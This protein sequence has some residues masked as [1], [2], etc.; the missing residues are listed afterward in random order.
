MKLEQLNIDLAR[1]LGVQ[2]PEKAS[3]VTLTIKPG[4]LPMVGVTY[5]LLTADG[6][7]TAVHQLQLRPVDW[8][9]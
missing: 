3:E 5:H 1:A 7:Q 4:Q 9:A 8:P 2:N 6:L